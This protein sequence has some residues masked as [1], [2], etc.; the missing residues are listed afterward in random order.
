MPA[1]LSVVLCS[2]NGAAGVD[3]CLNA[4]TAQTIYSR[5]EIIVVDDG[6]TD[7]TSMVAKRHGVI[8]IRHVINRGLA[9]ARNSGVQAAS[10]P[11]VA[12]LDDDCEPE[13]QW[14]EGIYF[15]YRED[16]IGVGGTIL[17][18][19]RPG[20][21]L[22]YLERNNPLRPLELDLVKSD[23]ILYR[24]YLYLKRQWTQSGRYDRRDVYSLVGANMSFRREALLDVGGFD[25]RFC[26]GAEEVDLCKRLAQAF[27]SR[28]LVFLPD[29]RVVHYFETSL[30]DTL[31]RSLGYGRGSARL[32]R[33][34]PNVG[35]TIF[36]GPV[37]VLAMLS[38]SLRLPTCAIVALAV[39]C[40][41]YP[42]GLRVAISERAANSL[43]DAYVQLAQ[44]TYDDIGFVQG[45]WRF[46]HLVP[47]PSTKMPRT[48]TE[49]GVGGGAGTVNRPKEFPQG[50]KTAWRV[51]LLT[52]RRLGLGVLIIPMTCHMC[53]DFCG[54]HYWATG[55]RR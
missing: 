41:L 8:I 24:F 21:M 7:D 37:I 50:A 22:G 3:R 31:R 20:F 35:P 11:I 14:A 45:L 1:D 39:P 42:R 55:R 12:F 46:R 40:A 6:S 48:I 9:A 25:E 2:Y 18:S 26:F 5:L 17:A 36:P 47:E 49:L 10:A 27:P 43:L 16:V 44:E 54:S 52:A 32:Y 33:K 34:W 23:A 53:I 15:G 29:A 28:R 19:G 30:R 51:G 13:T 38:L 4:L